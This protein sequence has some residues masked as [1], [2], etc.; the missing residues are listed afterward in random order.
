MRKTRLLAIL[1]IG[2]RSE[3]ELIQKSLFVMSEFEKEGGK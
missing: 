3:G 1:A 2:E